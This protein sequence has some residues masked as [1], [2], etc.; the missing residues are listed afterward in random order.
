MKVYVD[1]ISIEASKG[2]KKDNLLVREVKKFTKVN[3]RSK[4]NTLKIFYA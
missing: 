2:C 3:L 4:M 1:K